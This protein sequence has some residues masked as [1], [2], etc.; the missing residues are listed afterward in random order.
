MPYFVIIITSQH[1]Y[2]VFDLPSIDG[3]QFSLNAKKIPIA[4]RYKKKQ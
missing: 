1:V 2:I 3:Q 4:L